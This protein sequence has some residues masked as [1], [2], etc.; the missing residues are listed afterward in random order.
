M[1]AFAIVLRRSNNRYAQLKYRLYYCR[2]DKC[3]SNHHAL[4]VHPR[5]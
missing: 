1:I 2:R 4:F 5:W 3:Q